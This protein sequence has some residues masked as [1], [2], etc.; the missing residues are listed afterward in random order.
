MTKMTEKKENG[1]SS[2]FVL[3]EVPHPSLEFRK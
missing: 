2:N 3:D 1:L